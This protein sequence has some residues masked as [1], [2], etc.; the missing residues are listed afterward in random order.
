METSENTNLNVP[1]EQITKNCMKITQGEKDGE[2][3]GRVAGAERERAKERWDALEHSA[4]LW[5]S[6]PVIA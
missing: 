2:G 1:R 6:L 4:E 5:I 3:L